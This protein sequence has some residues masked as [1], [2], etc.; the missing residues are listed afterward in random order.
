MMAT[1]EHRKVKII[2]GMEKIYSEELDNL[3]SQPS[4]IMITKI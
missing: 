1:N 2:R 3:F 4:F